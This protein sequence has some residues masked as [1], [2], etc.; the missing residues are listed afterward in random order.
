MELNKKTVRQLRGLIVFTIIVLVAAV[1]YGVILGAIGRIL[2][3]LFP[4]FL[5][6]AIAFILN[7][8]MRGLEKM[9]GIN[10]LDKLK[11]PVSLALSVLLVA[12]ILL[13]VMV[14]VLPELLRT[15]DSLKNS[16]PEFL[17]MLHRQGEELF[18]RNQ[19]MMQLVDWVQV[20]WE[21]SI[22]NL[23]EFLRKG[24]GTVLS[25]TFSAAVTFLN[26]IFT[27]GISFIFA[28][29]I[30]L[31]KETLQ[32]QA[33]KLC[34]ALFPDHVTGRICYVAS[35]SQSVFSHF[36]AGQCLEA[37]ILG[38]MFFVVLSVLQLPY[39]LLIGVLIA[40]TALIPVFGAF[41]GCGVGVFLM[42]MVSPVTALLFLIIFFVLQQIEGNLIYP[43]VVGNSVGLP[44]IWVLVAVTVGGSAFGITGMLVFIPLCSVL[45]RLLREWTYARLYRQQTR[46][47]RRRSK[48]AQDEEHSVR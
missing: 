37:V 40:F 44:S 29:Y 14:L 35:I 12:G 19:D 4:F 46:P 9:A 30:L 1:N 11:R 39:A 6:G 32:R 3:V 17:R 23:M 38:T 26:G 8:P 5:G 7:V 10:K 48:D 13:V 43:Y 18:F 42:L 41:I 47:E 24:A 31:Q 36:L 21:S 15:I 2:A 25:G 28:M 34:L 20:D 45:Y 16:V 27:F 33:R 22:Y